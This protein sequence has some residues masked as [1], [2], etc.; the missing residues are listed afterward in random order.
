MDAI[1]IKLAAALQA[2]GRASWARL[3]EL[4]GLTAPAAAERVRKLEERGVVKGY[5]VL[6]DPTSMGLELAAFI[7]VTLQL[8]ASREGF[9]RDITSLP[10][11]LE[12]H[13]VAGDADYIIKVRCS[14]TAHLERLI[15][16]DLKGVSGVATTRTAIVLRT[17]KE[18][19]A[20]PIGTQPHEPARMQT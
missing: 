3:G 1:D 19:T 4:V 13:H 20:L 16:N 15:S 10:E 18:T 7:A 14:G 2:D 11:V 8:P 6:L 9:L 17:E 5:Y 12:C